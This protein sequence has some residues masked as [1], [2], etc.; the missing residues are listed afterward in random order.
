MFSILVHFNF[1]GVRAKFHSNLFWETIVGMCLEEEGTGS[2]LINLKRQDAEGISDSRG[3]VAYS[4]RGIAQSCE[5]V[6]DYPYM[7][8]KEG[9]LGLGGSY[10]M[11]YTQ[12]RRWNVIRKLLAMYRLA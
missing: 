7:K 9:A 6:S 1:L 3:G 5:G 8:N 2:T 4:P 10:T 11:P 12:T